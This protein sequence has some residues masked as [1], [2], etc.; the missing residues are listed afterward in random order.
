[1]AIV[2]DAESWELLASDLDIVNKQFKVRHTGCFDG[3]SENSNISEIVDNILGWI[4][5]EVPSD[6]N[7]ISI[8][9]VTSDETATSETIHAGSFETIMDNFY[10]FV[11]K[12]TDYK[13]SHLVTLFDQIIATIESMFLDPKCCTYVD[14]KHQLRFDAAGYSTALLYMEQVIQLILGYVTDMAY[15]L[16]KELTQI[17]EDQTE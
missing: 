14:T 8:L 9:F 16:D 15:E 17:E 2:T 5:D 13:L 10:A 7:G 3:T 11:T 1:M 4:F 6:K 12:Y